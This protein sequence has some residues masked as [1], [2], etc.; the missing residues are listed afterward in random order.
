MLR[1]LARQTPRSTR[2]RDTCR[3]TCF[4]RL[5]DLDTRSV[6]VALLGGPDSHPNRTLEHRQ[7]KTSRSIEYVQCVS[8]LKLSAFGKASLDTVS[9]IRQEL[10]PSFCCESSLS[11]T[12]QQKPLS[13]SIYMG[14]RVSKGDVKCP[15]LRH[16]T[17]KFCIMKGA[18]W[19][20]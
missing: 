12:L 1:P 3:G 16:S 18:K 14:E 6:S 9:D 19:S 13:L 10:L 17:S 15:K 2:H 4:I 5:P 11:S 8:G 20:S 7:S